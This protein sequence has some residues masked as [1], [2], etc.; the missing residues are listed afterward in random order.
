M[1]L[2]PVRLAVI[3]CEGYSLQWIKRLL[4]V[5]DSASLIAVS[6]VDPTSPGANYCRSHGVRVVG[7]ITELLAIEEIEVVVNPTPIHLHQPV[8]MQCLEA[9]RQVWLEKPAVA[10]VQA[11]DELREFVSSHDRAVPVCFNSLYTRLT[12]DLKRELVEGVYGRVVRVKGI[13]SWIRTSAYFGRNNWAGR[14]RAEGHWI[15][16]GDLNN[17]F[18]HVLCNN[19]F[20]AGTNQAAL[21]DLDQIEAELYR[22]NGMAC[23]DTSCVRIMTREGVEILSYL[24]LSAP[25]EI[26][27]L[28]VIETERATIFFE[29]FSRIRIAWQD[30]AVEERE[31]YQEHRM[32]MIAHL[33]RA[34]RLGTPYIGELRLLRPFTEAVNGAFESS[35]VVHEVPSTHLELE[36]IDQGSHHR[37]IQLDL[38]MQEAFAANALFSEMGVSWARKGSPFS[39]Q[40]YQSFPQRFREESDDVVSDATARQNLSAET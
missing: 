31:C 2:D 40:N 18:A 39:L 21:A 37:V 23:Q 9:G 5:P 26:A 25:R 33:C 22:C 32:E 27:P 10:T 28:T 12:Q 38:L 17:V 15:L 29:D 13:G 24:T 35:G 7:S 20:F 30:G 19:L 34:H 8:T 6:A 11:F 1:I 16:D 3:G 36:H 4:S 14:L